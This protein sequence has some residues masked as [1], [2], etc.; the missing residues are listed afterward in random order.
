MTPELIQ[1]FMDS[2]QVAAKAAAKADAQY[3][4][5]IFQ[6]IMS[7][8]TAIAVA[9]LARFQLNSHRQFN[10]RMDEL[11]TLSNALAFKEGEAAGKAGQKAK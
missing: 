4:L 9:F 5:T 6:V 7:S 10:S 1:F 2:L 8:V 11:K 3:Q